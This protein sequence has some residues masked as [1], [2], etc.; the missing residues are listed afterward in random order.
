MFTTKCRKKDFKDVENIHLK[1]SPDLAKK[2]FFGISDGENDWEKIQVVLYQ[3]LLKG[4]NVVVKIVFSSCFEI[5][6]SI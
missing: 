2:F 3:A 4:V 6:E 1:T 5:F